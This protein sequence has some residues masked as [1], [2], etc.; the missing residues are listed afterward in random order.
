MKKKAKKKDQA[1]MLQIGA[2]TQTVESASK[3]VM[4]ILYSP[5]GSAEKIAALESLGKI[6]SVNGTSVSS[7]HFENR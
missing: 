6:C 2:S 7:C 3:A 4:E 1:V 5:A